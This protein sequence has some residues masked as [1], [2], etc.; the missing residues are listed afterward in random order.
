MK[1]N[2]LVAAVVVFTM[3]FSTM[4]V[5][6]QLNIPVIG[7]ASAQ[8]G[9]D[10]YGNATTEI[11]YGQSYASGTIKINST[12]FTSGGSTTDYL[13]YYPDYQN[14]SN[15]SYRMTWSPFYINNDTGNQPFITGKGDSKALDTGG[16]PIT[17][18]RSG[19]WIFDKDTTHSPH[20]LSSID[21][22]IWVNT[23]KTYTIDSISDITYN[24]SGSLTVT[25]DTK[26]DSGCM[27][28]ITDPQN[29][30]IYNR[31]RSSS[32]SES[33]DYQQYFTSVG[34]YTVKAYRDKDTS[35]SYRYPDELLAGHQYTENYSQK[36][37]SNY[38][39]TF[40]M[41]S[42]PR[43]DYSVVGPWNPPE[44]NAS[45]IT[46][47]VKVASKAP[48]LNIAL[49][50]TSFYWGYKLRI[51]VNVTNTTGAG[52]DLG[53]GAVRLKKGG[54]YFDHTDLWI[55][56]TGNGNYTIELPR[57]TDNPYGWANIA[58]DIN[59]NGTWTVVFS[60]DVAGT[61]KDEWNGTAT[62]TIS[63]ASPPVQ[64]I[65]DNDGS[66]KASDK[67]VDIPAYTPGSGHATPLTV[68]FTIYGRS[69]TNDLDRAY[70]GDAPWEN[71]KN[72]TIKGDI[73][74]KATPTWVSGGTWTVDLVPTKPGGQI[75]FAIDWPGSDNG[76]ASA[77]H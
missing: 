16:E 54:Y 1:A 47:K 52:I 50:N 40:P 25:V 48:Q 21:G 29:K 18:N 69:I 15:N 32:E 64:L 63:S 26:G 14:Y 77:D 19:M 74:Y 56:D 70:Y 57:Y 51:D 22:F 23:S 38:T 37:G 75:T 20:D 3:L 10:K 43:Y 9:V 58:A 44:R 39:H 60:A 67:K 61:N 31:W 42:S 30:T 11:V 17:F 65:I 33:L 71:H 13:L 49:S 6:N 45:E 7:Q 28:A 35:S 12:A 53:A 27:I 41:E 62:F 5:L 34:T 4:V 72:I 55:N 59:A 2:K 46:F 24:E 68:T 76:T 8:P 66:G 73:L 36:Y